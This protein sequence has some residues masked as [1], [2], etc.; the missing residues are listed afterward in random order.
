[1]IDKDKMPLFVT[2]MIMLLIMTTGLSYAYFSASVKGNENAKDVVVEAGTLKL[3]YTD[4][5]AINAQ[6]IK[7]GWSTTK[8]VSVKNN[9][10]LDAYY[11][12]IWQSL[13]N[14]ITNDELVLSATCQRLN[15][16]GT[17]EG[18]CE[19]ISQAPISDMTIAKKISIESGI[20]HKYTFT[21]LFKETNANQNYNQ[22]K[23]FNGVLGIEEYKVP[24]FATD[25]W[26]TIIANVKAGYGSEYAV[27]STKEVNLGTTYGTHTLRVANTSTPNECSTTG[28]SQT[29]CGFVLEF[30]DVI[31]THKMNDTD[32][33]VGGWPSSSMYT[34][35]NNDIYNAIPSELKSAIIDTTVVSGH[36][37]TSG[38][39][40][41][42]STDKLY[43]L[44]T[45]EVWAQG[46]SNTINYDT[47][48]DVT[49]QL[50]YYKNL[51][52]STSN[53]SGAIKKNGTSASIWWLRAAIS[54]TT[55][56][57]FDVIDNGDWRG[58]YASYTRGV[59]P[60]FRLG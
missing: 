60:A 6:Y 42:T 50:D 7:P 31:T 18:T 54:G 55:N 21:I 29:A 57:F 37:K 47:A 27:G 35:V 28:F 46:S 58:N 20:T 44:S 15:A 4:G 48:R 19:S 9:G 2:G 39:T 30:A 14:G 32:T 10:T 24:D 33:N 45:A 8:E 11:N 38:E 41:F 49:R 26:S 40:N 36:G 22:G 56:F 59:A 25:S 53:Y 17:V 1:M 16:S 51:G 23:E 43:L 5:P 13:T 3:T 12:V 34:F 52:T